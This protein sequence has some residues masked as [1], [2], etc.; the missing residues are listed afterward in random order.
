[1]VKPES[2]RTLR[3]HFARAM[4]E[5]R[6]WRPF[7]FYLMFALVVGALLAAPV[8]YVRDE[9]KRFAFFLA[10]SFVLFAAI[11]F[12]AIL[13]FFD[14]ARKGFRE[15]ETVFREILGDKEFTAQLA[16]SVSAARDE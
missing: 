14:I 16:K 3:D 1:M 13:D 9:P 6:R 4:N 10:L 8:F 15:R 5:S 7:S 11:I 2:D 12:R